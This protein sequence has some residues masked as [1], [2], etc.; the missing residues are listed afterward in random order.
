MMLLLTSTNLVLASQI[1]SIQLYQIRKHYECRC[2]M[3]YK[4]LHTPLRWLDTEPT[5]RILNRFTAEFQLMDSQLS[6]DFAQSCASLVQV[7][8]IMVAA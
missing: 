5:G 3:T 8:G 4:V 6:S 1:F 2:Y 7:L